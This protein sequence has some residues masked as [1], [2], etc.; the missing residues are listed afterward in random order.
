MRKGTCEYKD[1]EDNTL[2][3]PERRHVASEKGMFNA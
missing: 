1:E 3:Q 2:G